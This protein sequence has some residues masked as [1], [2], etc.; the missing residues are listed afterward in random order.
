M[1]PESHPLRQLFL[2]LVSRHYAE[3]LGFHDPEVSAY[4]ANML[5]EFCEVDQLYKLRNTASKPLA[6]VGE[7]LLE[8]D[9]VYGPAGSLRKLWLP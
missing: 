6:D 7:M 2:D 4:V 3:E 8:S 1:I 5:A 9:P